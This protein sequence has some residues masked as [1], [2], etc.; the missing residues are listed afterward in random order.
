MAEAFSTARAIIL[1]GLEARAF[2]AAAIEVGRSNGPL[3]T[4]AF[5]RLTYDAS[6]SPCDLDTLFDL[7]SL[8]KVIATASLAMH[9]SETGRLPLDARV[10]DRLPSCRGADRTGVGVRHLLDHSSGL[11]AHARL[12]EHLE[13]R[14]A[15]ERAIADMPLDSR[16]G[17]VSVYSDLGF[18]LLGFLL[19]DAGGAPLDVQWR[20]WQA[21]PSGL[22]YCPAAALANR[23]APT[24]RDPRR[25]R[26]VHGEVHD[27]NAAALGGVAGHAG[28][29]GTAEAVGAFAR[30]VLETFRAPTPLGSPA[31]MRQFASRTGV[32]NSTRALAW[33][34]MK[35]TS[36]C[37]TLMSATAIGHTGFTGTSLWIDQSSDLYVVF[38]TNR[39]HPTRDNDALIGLRPRLHDA[40]VEAVKAG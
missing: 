3:W 34:T 38:L 9:H 29:F 6:A 8:T 37:G 19:E 20:E 4:E 25:G 10:A 35:P 21:A 28:L 39:V 17:A 2:P 33:D 13:G 23:I 40:I 14:S 15:F 16:P 24:E 36:S 5:G 12:F 22:F 30:L 26:L 31:L 7:A 27:E 32:P 1:S 18:I 11:P